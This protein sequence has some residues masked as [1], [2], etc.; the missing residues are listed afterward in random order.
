LFNTFGMPTST[1][2]SI[3]FELLGASV[4][5]ALIKIMAA[6]Q[7]F[8]AVSEYINTASA[9][10]IVSGILI[11]VGVAFTVGALVQ[12][13]ARLLFSFHYEQRLKWV[14]SLYGGLALSVMT[15]FLILK[16]LK[17]A[18]FVSADFVQWAA[19]HTLMIVGGAFVFDVGIQSQRLARGGAFW[20]LL[21]GDGLCRQ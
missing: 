15:Y 16:G 14:G 18:S 7:G 20:H 1:T 3:I 12:Y 11:S 6:D 17:G 19:S 13:L 10:A 2:V 5:V 8:S 21:A 9:L 4:A